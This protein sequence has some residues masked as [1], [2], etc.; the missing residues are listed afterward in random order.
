MKR[1]FVDTNIFLRI[2][3]EDDPEKAAKCQDLFRKGISRKTSLHTNAMVMAEIIWTLESYY[4][5]SRREI[6][7]KI[8]KILNTPNLK[9]EN[10]DLIAEAVALYEEKNIDYIDCFNAIYAKKERMDLIYSY[11]SDFDRLSMTLRREP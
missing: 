4:R 10:S 3:T 1:S 9:V 2:L 8:E 5:C 11:N 6:R 7:D